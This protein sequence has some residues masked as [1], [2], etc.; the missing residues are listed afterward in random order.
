MQSKHYRWSRLICLFA[1][2]KWKRGDVNPAEVSPDYSR[3]LKAI[4]ARKKKGE[5]DE[6]SLRRKFS[7]RTTQA[8]KDESGSLVDFARLCR[9]LLSLPPFF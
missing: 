5:A 1:W 3:V 2:L 9:S 7:V 4:I 8:F 6:A